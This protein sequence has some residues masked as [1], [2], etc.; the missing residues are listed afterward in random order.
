MSI[1]LTLLQ[2][3]GFSPDY[4]PWAS[5]VRIWHNDILLFTLIVKRVPV[6]GP[7]DLVVEGRPL[8]HLQAPLDCFITREPLLFL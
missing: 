1:P 8:L 7:S 4:N 3:D 6:G 2:N 5:A